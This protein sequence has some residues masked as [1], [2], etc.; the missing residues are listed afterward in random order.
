LR[1]AVGAAIAGDTIAFAPAL[2]AAGAATIQLSNVGHAGEITINKKL[3]INGPG[4]ALL[5]VKAFDPS[6]TVGN[7]SRVFH[8]DDGNAVVDKSILIRGLRLTGGDVTGD[9]G[10]ILNL[11]SL[12]LIRSS[13]SGNAA[14]RGGGI[15]SVGGNLPL[16]TC[17]VS[18][19]MAD[20]GGGIAAIGGDLTVDRRTVSGNTA[21]SSDG[22]GILK[23][24][25]G[26]VVVTRSTIAGNSAVG[27]G[28]GLRFATAN[29]MT[30]ADSTISGNSAA[31]GGG[32]YKQSGELTVTSSTISDNTASGSGG[33]VFAFFYLTDIRHSTITKNTAP[34]GQGSGV[35]SVG[36]G[37]TQTEVHSSIVA[38]NT[39]SDVDLVDGAIN[40]V[41]SNGY[42]LIGG[43][44]ASGVFVGMGD[45]I[46]ANPLLGPLADNGGPTHTHAPLAGSPAIDTGNPSAM[47]GV[48][49]VPSF[50]Q[51][52]NPYAR[53]YDGD[54]TGGARIDKGAVEVQP[55]GPPL[56]G[57]YD[58]DGV[59][60]AADYTVWRDALG[61]NVAMFDGADGDGNGMV[62]ANDYVVWKTHFGET[63]PPGAGGASGAPEIAEM[64]T[65]ATAFAASGQKQREVF[66][67]DAPAKPLMGAVIAGTKIMGRQE[68]LR[69][70]ARADDLLLAA[71]IPTTAPNHVAIDELMI[72][73]ASRDRSDLAF[74]AIDEVFA[75]STLPRLGT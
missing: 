48:G 51:R 73:D 45:Q 23:S 46:S 13:I 1:E 15:A 42:N 72:H 53:V 12:T 58:Q 74:A 9:G 70:S 43:G 22:G 24:A 30:I 38:G 61:Q 18:G 2:T 66:S 67:L 60:D 4:A 37:F 49:G 64:T 3:T 19:N 32:I 54:A 69:R 25:G 41:Q 55:I 17:V 21:Q 29:T 28:G 65:V 44:N 71:R 75:R 8:L 52:G 14:K 31:N 10:A 63:L 59:V 33:G 36:N 26:N 35:A 11:E 57:D 27:A 39:N 47:A 5:T 68:V 40:S 20:A 34:A 62:G 56:P 16:D 50:D 6:A 7:G